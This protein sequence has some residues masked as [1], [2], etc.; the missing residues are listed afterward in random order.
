[1][2]HGVNFGFLKN[3][4]FS[5]FILETGSGFGILLA[6]KLTTLFLL[7]AKKVLLDFIDSCPTQV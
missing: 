5:E 2:K 6:N 1:M 7:A 3:T 4:I